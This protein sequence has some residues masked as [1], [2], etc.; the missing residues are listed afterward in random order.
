MLYEGRKYIGDPIFWIEKEIITNKY[1]L[2]TEIYFGDE[3]KLFY[4]TYDN[5]K[6]A[7]GVMERLR[8]LFRDN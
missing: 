8:Y 6:T 5:K 1:L 7:Q 4:E 2:K 3:I